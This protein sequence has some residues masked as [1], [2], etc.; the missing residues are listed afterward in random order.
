MGRFVTSLKTTGDRCNDLIALFTR[1]FKELA[2]RQSGQCSL[3]IGSNKIGLG[4]TLTKTIPHVVTPH[5][6][7]SIKQMSF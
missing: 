1:Q 4:L 5:S 6:I 7:N 2:R 3:L